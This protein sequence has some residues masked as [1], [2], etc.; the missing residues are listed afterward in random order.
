MRRYWKQIVRWSMV[1]ALLFTIGFQ[2]FTAGPQI[3]ITVWD[4]PHFREF[5]D[6]QFQPNQQIWIGLS[7]RQKNSQR[8]ILKQE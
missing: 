5:Q 2:S 8:C 1:V 7:L 3:T 6:N 4:Y